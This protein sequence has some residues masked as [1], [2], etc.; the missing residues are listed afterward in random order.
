MG[1]ATTCLA[2]VASLL[3]VNVTLFDTSSARSRTR[4]PRLND[5]SAKIQNKNSK[6]KV[7][8]NTKAQS[9]KSQCVI[10]AQWGNHQSESWQILNSQF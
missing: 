5:P 8:E 10:I 1:M 6:C 9:N 7:Q 3:A 4:S 2:M